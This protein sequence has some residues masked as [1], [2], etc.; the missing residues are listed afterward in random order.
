ML[1]FLEARRLVLDYVAPLPPERVSLNHAL[2]L[3]AAQ[4]LHAADPLPP[5]TNSAMDGFALHSEDLRGATEQAPV[6]L[7]VTGDLSAGRTPDAPVLPGEALRIMTG[8]PMPEGADTVVPLEHT[9][10]GPNWV[11]VARPLRVGA[12]IRLAG[13]DLAAGGLVVAAGTTL[14]P[15]E[16]G[17]LA[18]AGFAELLVHRRARV[19]I[20]TTGDELVDC[21]TRPGPGQIRDANL[22]A[23]CAQIAACGAVAV[24]FPRIK[25]QGSAMEQV[26]SGA[27]QGCDLLLTT[28]G[29]SVG[30]YDF[31]KP[32][33][34]A[35]G[36]EP[37]F[38][39]VAQK[40]GGPLGFWRLCGK[41]VF[42]LPGNPVAAMVMVEEYVRLAL[43]RMMG[44]RWLHRPERTALL[45]TAWA[46]RAPDGRVHFLRVVAR[47]ADGGWRATLTGPQGSGILSSMLHANALAVIR[48]E[49]TNLPAGSPVRLHLT[50]QAEDH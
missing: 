49:D 45:D 17:V 26:L 11:E 32:A 24:P 1:T 38:W 8:A 29:V 48:E 18:A 7:R 10:T 40:P 46:K 20:L 35:L 16:I 13:E 23:L 9:H 14:R 50:E 21:G 44:H 47:E 39:R 6:R 30:D 36:A 33:L 41:P 2:G 31:V 3:A 28:G 19:A 27:I 12:N 34:E 42:G 4:D 5:F 22:P 25:D 43:R 15:G 37:V